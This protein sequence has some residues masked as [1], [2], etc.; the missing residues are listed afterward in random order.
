MSHINKE[1]WEIKELL[2]DMSLERAKQLLSHA[3]KGYGITLEKALEAIGSE[4]IGD[5]QSEEVRTI[6]K[7]A[8]DNIAEFAVASQ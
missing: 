7:A 6:L 4:D 3:L 5:S 1:D 8:L 2:Q